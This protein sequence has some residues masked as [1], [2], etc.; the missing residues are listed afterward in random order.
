[1][2]QEKPAIK[3]ALFL[4]LFSTITLFAIEYGEVDILTEKLQSILRGHRSFYVG[5]VMSIFTG[6]LVALFFSIVKYSRS[7][8]DVIEELSC[9]HDKIK[10]YEI[11]KEQ[12]TKLDELER[13]L[14]DLKKDMIDVLNKLNHMLKFT[15]N[16]REIILMFEN[17][18]KIVIYDCD[19]YS[20]NFATILKKIELIEKH[21]YSMEKFDAIQKNRKM[22]YGKID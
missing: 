3:S 20:E 18:I 6:A 14:F 21:Y 8:R 11:C 12:H 5:I 19:V 2:R 10:N 17:I 9:L 15:K 4:I 16:E 1:M 13:E 7:K 22:L